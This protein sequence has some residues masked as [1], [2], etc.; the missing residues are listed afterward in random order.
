MNT[1]FSRKALRLPVITALAAAALVLS[2]CG[3]G[4]AGADADSG[5]EAPADDIGLMTPGTLV[6]GMNLQYKPQMFLEGDT[7]SGYDVDLLNALADELGVELDIQNLDFNGLIPG[8]QSRQF[9]M[10]SVGLGATDE[11]KEV[12]DFSR[13]Y[14]PYATILGVQPGEELGST[15]EDYNQEGV[16]ITALQGSTGEQLVRDTFPNATVAGFPDQNAALLEVATGRA[17]AVVVE[18]YILAEFDRSNPDQLTALDLDEPLSLYYGAW[19]VQKDNG[20][21]VDQL[22]AFLCQAQE[23]GTLEELY[24]KWMAPTMPEMP[25][26]C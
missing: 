2:A 4:N 22:D 7:P 1:R 20:A 13:G 24:T 11:R 6:V 3:G 9:D 14:V 21:L 10:V 25:G 26:G 8:L 16:V 5:G 12:I 18:D 17:D 23:D 15:L 19:G